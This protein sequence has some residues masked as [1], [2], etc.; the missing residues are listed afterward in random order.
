MLPRLSHYRPAQGAFTLVE[1]VVA[2]AVAM[3]GMAGVMLLNTAHL[4]LVKSG[5]QSNAA[6]LCLQERVEQMRLGDWRKITDPNYLRNTLLAA[7]ARSA[8]PLD[9]VSERITVTAYPDP[10]AA[11][12]LVVERRTSG[13]RVT[14]VSGSGL[15]SQRLARVELQVGWTGS[16][17]RRR[18]RATTTLI[19]NGGIS[20]MNLPGFGGDTSA[21]APSATPTASGAATPTPASSATPTPAPSNN[22]NG[23]GNVGGQS[24]TR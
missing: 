1:T 4:R 7:P 5:R 8:A 12:Q 6:T 17:Q 2:T 18:Q 23:R 3:I 10:A 16:D 20:R 9:R 13:E 24:G 15:T 14:L 19:S 22:G 21:P 11:Q